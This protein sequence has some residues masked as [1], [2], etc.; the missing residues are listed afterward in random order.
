[1]TI[2]LL[3]HSVRCIYIYEINARNYIKLKKIA[4]SID[5]FFVDKKETVGILLFTEIKTHNNV[6]YTNR[7]Q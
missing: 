6:E 2:F 1:M 5:R 4:S 7:Y 3:I